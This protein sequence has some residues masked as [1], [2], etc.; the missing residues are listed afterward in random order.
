MV[1][2]VPAP[3][4]QCYLTLLLPL[5]V[6]GR[7]DAA[8]RLL[9]ARKVLI[10]LAYLS[11]EVLYLQRPS[12]E[13]LACQLPTLVAFPG[14]ATWLNGGDLQASDNRPRRRTWRRCSSVK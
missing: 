5:V 8:A 1:T 2:Q 9:S 7:L 14:A 10:A 4:V 3:S 12:G 13:V 6:C 11:R